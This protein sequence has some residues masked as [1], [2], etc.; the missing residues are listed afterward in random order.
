LK[1]VEIMDTNYEKG[2]VILTMTAEEYCNSVFNDNSLS[3]KVFKG[4]VKEQEVKYVVPKPDVEV[5]VTDLL[6]KFGVP[7]HIKGFSF[8]R[9]SVLLVI[10]KPETL[11]SMTKVLYPTIAR[12]HNTTPSRVER[13]IRHGIEVAF[14]KD[15]DY[16]MFGKYFEKARKSGKPTNSEFIATLADEI[17]LDSPKQAAS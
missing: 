5:Q 4:P 10:K 9:E 8:L 2:M 12:N 7:R 13:A 15:Y 11:D 3:S 14:A 1:E 6:S 17:R 16:E